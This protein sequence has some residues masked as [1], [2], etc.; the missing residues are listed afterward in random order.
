MTRD[1]LSGKKEDDVV[2]GEIKVSCPSALC[3]SVLTVKSEGLIY[4][5]RRLVVCD[6][7]GGSSPKRR[8]G[9]KKSRRDARPP[10]LVNAENNTFAGQRNTIECGHRGCL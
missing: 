8:K 6:N 5:R 9:A 4:S 3:P 2:V 10:I 1:V 7:C